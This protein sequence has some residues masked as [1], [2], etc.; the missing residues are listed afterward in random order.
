MAGLP[1][2]AQ[3]YRA[4][5]TIHKGTAD[6]RLEPLSLGSTGSFIL[7]R[8]YYFFKRKQYDASLVLPKAHQSAY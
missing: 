8:D 1:L 7:L 4:L 6:C 5:L 3:S 2:R